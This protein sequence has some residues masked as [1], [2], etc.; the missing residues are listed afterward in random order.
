MKLDAIREAVAKGLASVTEKQDL[1]LAAIN[2]VSSYTFTKEELIKVEDNHLFVEQT[3]WNANHDNYEVVRVLMQLIPLSLPYTYK[4]VYKKDGAEYPLSGEDATSTYGPLYKT[5]GIFYGFRT[6]GDLFLAADLLANGSLCIRSIG[7]Y[8]CYVLTKTYK[9]AWCVFSV[10]KGKAVAG[11][12]L[13]PQSSSPLLFDQSI[14]NVN[15]EFI[16]EAEK[17]SNDIF[18]YREMTQYSNPR[19][20]GKVVKIEFVDK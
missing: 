10:G 19:G 20:S 4:F 17:S 13:K 14:W 3:F 9:K 8:G 16:F 1:I 6:T 11:R 5:G 7:P 15:Y 12:D 2:G 18:G